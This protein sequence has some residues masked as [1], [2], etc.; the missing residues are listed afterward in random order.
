MEAQST[1]FWSDESMLAMT[2]MPATTNAIAPKLLNPGPLG[3]YAQ[4]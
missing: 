1:A 2:M 4:Q 3:L